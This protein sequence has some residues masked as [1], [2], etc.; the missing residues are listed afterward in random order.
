MA[1]SFAFEHIFEGS[2]GPSSPFPPNHISMHSSPAPFDPCVTLI[3]E[4]QTEFL[5]LEKCVE[6]WF[7]ASPN[8]IP[9]HPTGK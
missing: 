1:L 6:I 7:G 5:G 4:H 8:H 2:R 3:E 9:P